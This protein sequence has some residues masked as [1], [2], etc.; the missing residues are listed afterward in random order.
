MNHQLSIV[1]NA[2]RCI[3][4]VRSVAGVVSCALVSSE[5]TVLGRHFREDEQS[6][7]LFAVMCATVLA[8][9]DTACGSVHVRRPSSVTVAA[10]DA[11]IFI[12]SAGEAALIA[13][14]I[15]KSA[16]L[17]TVQRRLSELAVRFGEVA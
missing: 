11:T 1:E 8:S 14:V 17:P 15:H 12:V 16:D 5:G 10:A 2:Q 3:N 9:A 13:A 7:P 6:S 4:E